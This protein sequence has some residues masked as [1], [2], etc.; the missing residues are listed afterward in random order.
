[1]L[2]CVNRCVGV[3]L[4]VPSRDRCQREERSMGVCACVCAYS[5]AHIYL[6]EKRESKGK[7]VLCVLLIS[8]REEREQR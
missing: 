7:C 1:M 2:V 3:H 8:S 4:L 5:P 6:A